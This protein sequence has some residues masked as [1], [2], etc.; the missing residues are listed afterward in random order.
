[1]V[2]VADGPLWRLLAVEAGTAEWCSELVRL[3]PARNAGCKFV[4]LLHRFPAAGRGSAA[5]VM[6][7]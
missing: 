4:G 5:G 7:S 1:M 6:W 2:C 3:V